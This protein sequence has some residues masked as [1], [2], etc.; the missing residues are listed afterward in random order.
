MLNKSFQRSKVHCLALT[1]LLSTPSIAQEL[2][3]Y[4][5]HRK[6]PKVFLDNGEAKGILPDILRYVEERTS[7]KFR[8]ELRPWKRAYR[9]AK[10]GSGGIVGLSM[11]DERL[12]IFDYSDA[13]FQ[14]EIVMVVRK[15]NEFD[16]SDINNLRGKTIGARRGSSY[17]QNFEQGK[18][19]VFRVDEDDNAQ[20]RLKKLLAGRIDVALI[21]PGET[22]VD[23][24]IEQD[25]KLRT[26]K[27]QLAILSVPFARDPNYLGFAKTMNMRS[28]LDQVNEIIRNGRRSGDIERII[29]HHL[30][31]SGSQGK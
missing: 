7:F 12:K 16:Y 25:E 14:D 18:Q 6:P 28:V 1:L 23:S 19:G 31:P 15:E 29:E 9:N 30:H 24:A 11:N 22:A 21:G 10:A 17:G 26:Q 27:N 20:Q 5:N 8:I 2:I 3:I 13:L 4:G